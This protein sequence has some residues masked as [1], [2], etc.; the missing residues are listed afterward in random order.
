MKELRKECLRL[1]G[2]LERWWTTRADR[3]AAAI[4]LRNSAITEPLC[5][6]CGFG[7][8]EV[9][10]LYDSRYDPKAMICRLCLREIGSTDT[11]KHSADE[12]WFCFA[13][14]EPCGGGEE[15]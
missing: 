7:A 12:R 14:T 6:F 2:S 9:G 1:A 3:R 5:S 11:S 8:N 4:L 10:Q 15:I 13:P